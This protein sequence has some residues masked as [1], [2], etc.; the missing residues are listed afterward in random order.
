VFIDA[1]KT[2]YDADFEK[3]LPKMKANGL[4]IIDNIVWGGRVI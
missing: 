2:G 3:L 4:F 1:D